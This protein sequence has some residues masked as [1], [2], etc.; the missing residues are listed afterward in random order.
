MKNYLRLTEFFVDISQVNVRKSSAFG[1]AFTLVELLVV[2]A[3]IGVL[4]ALMLAAVQ[5][6]REAA[7][8]AECSNNLRQLG[9]AVI[10]HESALGHFPTGGWGCSWTGDP[11]RGT[12][13]KQPGGWVYNIL[14]YLE[15]GALHD[16]GSGL[17]EIEKRKA[18]TI[19]IQTPIKILNCPTRRAS[20]PY[21]N[22]WPYELY[23]ATTPKQLARADYAIN[24]GNSGSNTIRSGDHGG[25]P[26]LE[27]G[28]TT[29]VWV[30]TKGYSGISYL[31][32]S[33]TVKQVTDGTTKTYLIG[34][35]YLASRHYDTGLI[36]S[37]RGHM[38]SGMAPDTVRMAKTSLVPSQDGPVADT[39]RFGSTH[40]GGC[41]FVFCDGSVKVI[42]YEIDPQIHAQ[43]G[44]RRDGEIVP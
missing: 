27:A 13:S 30:S 21:P 3:V 14:P 15:E 16:S 43:Y 12:E 38:Y 8:K 6:A 32:S 11:D 28:D 5:A 2:I 33:V 18:A 22:A 25:P 9:L 4:I 10:E 40:Q 44:R 29:F 37:D 36:E 23:N 35:S 26:T 42:S 24:G 41:Y 20:I 39:L 34:E 17:A 7:R 31:R 1:R 19:V